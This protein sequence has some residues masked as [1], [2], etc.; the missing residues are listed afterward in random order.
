[1]CFRELNIVL[2]LIKFLFIS[3]LC[4]DQHDQIFREEA[5]TQLESETLRVKGLKN[6]KKLCVKNAAS[7]RL[8]FAL[9]NHTSKPRQP[10]KR[11]GW[12]CE[13]IEQTVA[14]ASSGIAATLLEGCRTAHSALKLPLNLQNTKETTCNI[15]KHS[16]MA[17]FLS[18]SK[19]IIWDE[20]TINC[21]R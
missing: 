16:A 17:K 4:R 13:I 15:S 9:L 6:N 12:K 8:D 5:A 21:C 11:L 3:K 7:E 19:I 20:C 14:V 10:A 1:M 18:E 2:I